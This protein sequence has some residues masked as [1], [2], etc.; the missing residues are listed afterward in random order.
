MLV[1]GTLILVTLAVML[2]VLPFRIAVGLALVVG[3]VTA[4]F[5]ARQET[6]TQTKSI[7]LY[8][9]TGIFLLGGIGCMGNHTAEYIWMD[10]KYTAYRTDSTYRTLR[11]SR[12][13]LC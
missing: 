11:Y 8:I 9:A 4:L 1:G 6:P 13:Y 7:G 10:R 12:D 2:F 3:I 5:A